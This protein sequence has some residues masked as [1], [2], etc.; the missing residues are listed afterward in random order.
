M[1]GGLTSA[2]EDDGEKA[3][4]LQGI[5]TLFDAVQ[6]KSLPGIDDTGIDTVGAPEITG[7]GQVKVYGHRTQ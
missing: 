1:H 2:Y 5:D 7:R 6:F 3:F 4:F